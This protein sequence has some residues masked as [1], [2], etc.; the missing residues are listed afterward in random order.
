MNFSKPPL[1]Q[2]KLAFNKR[3]GNE[4]T[5]SKKLWLFCLAALFSLGA[6]GGDNETDRDNGS[7][8]EQSDERDDGDENRNNDNRDDDG[9]GDNRDNGR[10][11]DDNNRSN[12]NRDDD[13]DDDDKR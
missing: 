7:Q 11:D 5:L 2:L 1:S 10:D 12:D 8:Y 13:R 3:K 6:C 4:M 9:N